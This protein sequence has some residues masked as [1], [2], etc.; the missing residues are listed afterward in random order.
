MGILRGLLLLPL[1]PVEG[2]AWMA[3]RLAAEAQRQFED[4]GVIRAEL[5]DLAAARDRG[6]IDDDDYDRIEE[7]LLRRM[8]STTTR[9]DRESA[10]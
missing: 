5:A 9:L 2:V 6:E 8:Q 4:P 7:E 1:A 3:E 10:R